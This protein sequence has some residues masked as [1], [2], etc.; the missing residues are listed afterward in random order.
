MRSFF[1]STH[2]D[3]AHE[4]ALIEAASRE[5]N[6]EFKVPGYEVGWFGATHDGQ[7]LAD[8]LLVHHTYYMLT[9]PG[10][11][12]PHAWLEHNGTGNCSAIRDI[13]YLDVVT[14]FVEAGNGPDIADNKVQVVAIDEGSWC[15]VDGSWRQT[16]YRGVDA[17]C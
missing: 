15:D 5:L 6:T 17:A 8:G 2:P 13:L 9:I 10:H 14:L 12:L 3:H 16:Q 4:R 11:H 7:Q 1:D